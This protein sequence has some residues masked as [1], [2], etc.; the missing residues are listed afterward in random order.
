MSR[1]TKMVTNVSTASSSHTNFEHLSK[2]DRCVHKW[3]T[4]GKKIYRWNGW[5]RFEL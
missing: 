2:V 3:P 4:H 1:L 5:I